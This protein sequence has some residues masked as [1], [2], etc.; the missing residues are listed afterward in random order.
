[1]HFRY[2]LCCLGILLA[3]P[4]IGLIG[5]AFTLP[6]SPSGSMYLLCSSLFIAGLIAAPFLRQHFALLVLAGLM[7]IIVIAGGRVL[8]LAQ[9][10]DS[11]IHMLALPGA[12]KPYWINSVLD[13]QDTLTFGEQLFHFVG[14]DSRAE[15]EN[16]SDAFSKAYSEMRA[17]GIYPSPV[18]GTYLNLQ[19]PHHFD[20]VIIEPQGT[21]TFGLVFLHGYMGNVTAQCWEIAQAIQPLGGV[22]VCPS[23][24]WTGEWWLPDGQDIIQSTFEYLRAQGIEKFYLGGFSNGGFSIGR[25][26]SQWKDIPELNGLIFIDGFMNGTSIR[27]VGLPILIIEGA[28]DERVPVTLARQ[29][30][31]D[32]GDLGTYVEVEGDHFLIMKHPEQV[33]QAIAEWLEL[34]QR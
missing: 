31:E 29:F 19:K 9:Q 33:Q 16:L 12:T 13:E 2:L 14:G 6:V 30:A 23:T 27:E 18:V 22:T 21:P 24:K 3:L 26:A 8:R 4:L 10:D 34:Q 32:V 7:G 15:H 5:L 17:Q 11:P 25:L 20:A 1:M 28:Q